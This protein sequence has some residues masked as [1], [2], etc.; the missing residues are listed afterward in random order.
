MTRT[1][2]ADFVIIKKLREGID[3]SDK[4]RAKAGRRTH[5]PIDS[6]TQRKCNPTSLKSTYSTHTSKFPAK[7]YK[8]PIANRL[9]SAKLSEFYHS[10]R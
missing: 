8:N 1:K 5:I 2:A 6:L 10:T 4:K 7:A 3:L 9:N